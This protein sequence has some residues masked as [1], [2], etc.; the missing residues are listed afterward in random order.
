MCRMGQLSIFAVSFIL[1][2]MVNQ[3]FFAQP[4]QSVFSTPAIKPQV[5]KQLQPRN[6]FSEHTINYPAGMNV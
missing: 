1:A 5:I 6:Y 2:I 4:Q 3:N